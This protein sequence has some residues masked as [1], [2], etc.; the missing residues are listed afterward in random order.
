MFTI[1]WV[2]KTLTANFSV[3]YLLIFK[4][5]FSAIYE[6]ILRPNTPLERGIKM[7]ENDQR[8]LFH[9]LFLGFFQSFKF[10]KIKNIHKIKKNII[11]WKIFWGDYLYYNKDYACQFLLNYNNCFLRIIERKK[12]KEIMFHS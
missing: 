7:R 9:P 3:S 2:M 12:N 4:S 10:R 6:A 8:N 5:I 1:L 11:Y